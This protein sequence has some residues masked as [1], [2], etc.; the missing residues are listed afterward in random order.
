MCEAR[1]MLKHVNHKAF[2]KTWWNY[3]NWPRIESNLHQLKTRPST[4]LV[5]I[6]FKPSIVSRTNIRWM[7]GISNKW[8]FYRRV[9]INIWNENG[10]VCT[11]KSL[12]TIDDAE[13]KDWRSEKMR[14]LPKKNLKTLPYK[15]QSL[16]IQPPSEKRS[17]APA[18]EMARKTFLVKSKNTFAQKKKS[19]ACIERELYDHNY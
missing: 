17:R 4:S 3:A 7:S 2:I 16:I 9:T 11:S 18:T 6:R 19:W 13:N 14:D 8:R 12:N 10:H 15:N 1:R 5:V